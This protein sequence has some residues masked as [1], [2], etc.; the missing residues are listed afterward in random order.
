[1][2]DKASI[3]ILDQTSNAIDDGDWTSSSFLS[4]CNEFEVSNLFAFAMA[5]RFDED[6]FI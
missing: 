1:M 6:V 5:R 4:S 3:L 2:L